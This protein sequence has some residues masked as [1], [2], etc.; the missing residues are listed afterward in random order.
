MDELVRYL[1][2][3]VFLQAQSF[4]DNENPV[5]PEILLRRAGLSP[6]EIAGVLGK[7]EA[8]VAKAIQRAK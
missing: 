2:A 4:M 5:K 6:V 3:L 1:K 7:T 8:A